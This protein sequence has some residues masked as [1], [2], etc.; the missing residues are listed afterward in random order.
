M[1]GIIDE[2]K[3]LD[4][5][6]KDLDSKIEKGEDLL[7]ELKARRLLNRMETRRYNP[8][9]HKDIVNNLK[10][11][12]DEIDLQ[13]LTNE[14]QLLTH[15]KERAEHTWHLKELKQQWRKQSAQDT[16]ASIP[17]DKP[18]TPAGATG[19]PTGQVTPGARDT[20]STSQTQGKAKAVIHFPLPLGAKVSNIEMCFL[21]NE[22]ET[23]RITIQSQSQVFHFAQMGFL[24]KRKGT[25]NCLWGELAIYLG[26]TGIANQKN[27]ERIN[28]TLQAFFETE[29]KLLNKRETFFKISKQ[30]TSKNKI[31]SQG[32][33]RECPS[34]YDRHN[35]F[36][37]IC[38]EESAHC[39]ECHDSLL[40]HVD[41]AK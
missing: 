19:N 9:F 24:D 20:A 16:P 26:G 30:T 3:Y 11:E 27:S 34:C 13:I 6:I 12:L 5:R 32:K 10:R 40:N 2:I 25:A 28:D 8:K 38:K 15:Q 17:Q 14:G 4:D 41:L 21:D 29:Q 39:Q 31:A 7:Q 33:A 18:Q 23:V 36:C 37:K 1:K 22:M 35:H